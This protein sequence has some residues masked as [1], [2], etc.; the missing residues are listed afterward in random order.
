MKFLLKKEKW[1]G[2]WDFFSSNQRLFPKRS[3][4]SID[5]YYLFGFTQ[6]LKYSPKKTHFIYFLIFEKLRIAQP[7]EFVMRVWNKSY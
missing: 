7:H 1:F 4:K 6:N 5:N 3:F 2:G